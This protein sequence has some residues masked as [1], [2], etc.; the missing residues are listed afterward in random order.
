MPSP[1]GAYAYA[2]GTSFSA[3]ISAGV[4]ALILSLNSAWTPDQVRLL[5]LATAV[6][7][8]AMNGYGRVDAFS[9]LSAAKTVLAGGPF[10]VLPGSPGAGAAAVLS[11][12]DSILAYP[13]PWRSDRHSTVPLVIGN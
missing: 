10:P 12:L 6:P 7:S 2:S 11:N 1:G 5:M 9:A 8:G 13:N 4:A 3:P